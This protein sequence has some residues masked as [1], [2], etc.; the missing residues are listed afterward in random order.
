M[1]C[2]QGDGVPRGG[3]DAPTC[4]SRPHYVRAK[5]TN[6]LAPSEMPEEPETRSLVSRSHG[7]NL[8]LRPRTSPIT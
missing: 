1:R 5:S 3:K 2:R 4:R 7:R 6:Y 8:G